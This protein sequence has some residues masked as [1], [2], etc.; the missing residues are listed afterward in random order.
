M[1]VGGLSGCKKKG[2]QAIIEIEKFGTIK[3][4][5]LPDVAPK[6]VENFTKLSKDGYYNG[7]TFHR[8]IKDFMIQG[9]DPKGDGTGGESIWKKPFQDEFSEK[10]RNFSGALSMANSGPNTNG[11]Q[12]FIVKTPPHAYKDSNG[13]TVPVTKEMLNGT[14]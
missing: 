3:V 1:V 13:N 14:S 5:L 4:D 11:S 9:G 7:L 2:P 6:A 10:A 12:F 8:V